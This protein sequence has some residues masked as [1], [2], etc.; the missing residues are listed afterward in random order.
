MCQNF[1]TRGGG[2]W[3][4]IV[5]GELIQCCCC[6]VLSSSSFKCPGNHVIRGF[7][8]FVSKVGSRNSWKANASNYCGPH[9]GSMSYHFLSFSLSYPNVLFQIH[10]KSL[11]ITAS[12]KSHWVLDSCKFMQ[13]LHKANGFQYLEQ[14]KNY[15]T[16]SHAISEVC[17]HSLNSVL[18]L[19]F[20]CR[21]TAH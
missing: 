20:L 16:C 4:N 17:N 21:Y 14:R 18:S 13:V 15:D 8:S 12:V 19:E 2:T 10:S 3:P 11:C 1:A 6:A 5:Y 7:S 9:G